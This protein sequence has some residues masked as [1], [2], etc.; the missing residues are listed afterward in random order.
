MRTFEYGVDGHEIG[1]DWYDNHGQREGQEFE[2]HTPAGG[3]ICV[4][5]DSDERDWW[6]RGLTGEPPG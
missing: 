2:N 4:L 1:S 5:P 3:S 6:C